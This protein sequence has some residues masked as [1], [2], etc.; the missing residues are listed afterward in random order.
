MPILE[1]VYKKE[2]VVAER[3]YAIDATIVRIMKTRKQLPYT[4]LIQE[5]LTQSHLFKPQVKSV[6]LRIEKLIDNFFLERD[7]ADKS[8][9]N[10]LA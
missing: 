5:V 6:K 3:E 2:K 8:M 1:E 10:Y 4:T 7:A 9:L